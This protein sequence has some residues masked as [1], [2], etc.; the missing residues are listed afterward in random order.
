MKQICRAFEILV[1]GERVGDNQVAPSRSFLR[2]LDD[3]IHT[4]TAKSVT[5]TLFPVNSFLSLFL[6]PFLRLKWQNEKEI[7]P[8]VSETILSTLFTDYNTDKYHLTQKEFGKYIE[9]LFRVHQKEVSKVVT[10]DEISL[11]LIW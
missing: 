7:S 3:K 10:S 2:S 1:E 8:I 4:Y 11:L 6:F 5:K 9:F